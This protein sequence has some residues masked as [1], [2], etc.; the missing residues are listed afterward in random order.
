MKVNFAEGLIHFRQAIFAPQA[1]SHAPDEMLFNNLSAL[2]LDFDLASALGIFNP[3]PE[4]TPRESHDASR[5]RTI[6]SRLACLG[7]LSH[8]SR[9]PI[10]DP[11]LI[12]AIKKF[13]HDA[14]LTEDGWVG[15]QT[16]HALQE[17]VSFESPCHVNHWFTGN[18]AGPALARSIA[19]RLHVL[20]LTDTLT[21]DD[22]A[23]LTAGLQQFQSVA[24]FLHLAEKDIRPEVCPATIDL[25]FDQDLLVEALATVMTSLPKDVGHPLFSF[26][27]S[28]AKVELWL[29]GYDVTP[30]GFQGKEFFQP[31]P[32]KRRG[33]Q[34]LRI[35]LGRQS[36]LLSDDSRLF[37]ALT[38]YW[39]D[40][41]K[42]EESP[43]LAQRF[44]D[45][46]PAF[47]RM[48][49]SAILSQ[50]SL[51]EAEKSAL[52]YQMVAKQPE[53]LEAIWQTALSLGG[54]MWDGMGS[55]VFG[56]LHN[57]QRQPGGKTVG[58]GRNISRLVYHQAMTAYDIARQA[59]QAF[60]TQIDNIFQRELQGS[61]P[62]HIMMRHDRD[63]DFQVFINTDGDQEKITQFI[64]TVAQT[65]RSFNA[66]CRIIGT[67][68]S[69]L[70]L[71]ISQ[72]RT[73]WAGLIL[74]LLQLADRISSLGRQLP[75]VPN[76]PAT[77]ESNVLPRT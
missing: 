27:A 55:R 2:V 45:E 37:A 14:G 58:I 46:F 44:A 68:M 67:F 18:C 29:A 63:L 10:I 66:T 32:G 16:W 77:P 4:E 8:D 49:A 21:F 54:Q 30:N 5:I 36:L 76:F 53:Q 56:W 65:S 38:S 28:V 73:G 43:G 35:P 50:K 40:H 23:N 59:L 11:F 13:Q 9:L 48:I 70:S 26:A 64:D 74:T 15:R 47:F 6:R 31:A 52:L 34:R 24:A 3:L 69:T 25:L 61:D 60:P 20:G 39:Q 12:H 17:L 1:A 19:L 72:G 57:L 7:Y 41:G 75:A 71:F 51:P 22:A 62:R 42:E 33:K